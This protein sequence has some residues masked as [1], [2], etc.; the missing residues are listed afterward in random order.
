MNRTRL[1]VIE[2]YR[3]PYQAAPAPDLRSDTGSVRAKWLDNL[4]GGIGAAA[5]V[6]AVWLAGHG[7][8]HR[9]GWVPP[10][11]DPAVVAVAAGI[12]GL[13]VFGFLMFLRSALDEI[14]EAGEWNQVQIELDDLAAQVE[15]LTE[16]LRVANQDKLNLQAELRMIVAQSKG[17]QT[18][19]APTDESLTAYRDAATLAERAAAGRKWGR[20]YMK[21]THNW[22]Q[23]KW[24]QARAVLV[25]AKVVST[26]SKLLISDQAQQAA[27]IENYRIR[28]E[29]AR[30]VSGSGVGNHVPGPEVND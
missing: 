16:R 26:D 17:K 29:K 24:E 10:W 22:G 8:A 18:Y 28:I 15:D 6:V 14:V 25:A 1:P 11:P 4:G 3:L 2:P 12:A 27:A 21:T 7:A 5:V 20:D 23:T 13:L 30:A 19:V 9:M